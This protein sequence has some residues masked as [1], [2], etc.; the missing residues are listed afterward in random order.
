MQ[1]QV[2]EIPRNTLKKTTKTLFYKGFNINI[3]EDHHICVCPVEGEF[4]DSLQQLFASN[5]FAPRKHRTPTKHIR[6]CMR[7][8]GDLKLLLETIAII[9]NFY[10]EKT[11]NKNKDM[12]S[13]E[14]IS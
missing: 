8:Y 4:P 5:N 9:D 6:Q 3:W 2:R 12:G 14:S 11:E 13:N 7:K 1:P 10:S